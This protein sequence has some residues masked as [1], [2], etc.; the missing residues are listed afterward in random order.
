MW[1][2]CIK[3]RHFETT[4]SI[5]PTFPFKRTTWWKQRLPKNT[6]WI[7]TS[8]LGIYKCIYFNP[9]IIVE[10]INNLGFSYRLCWKKSPRII[11]RLI[12]GGATCVYRRTLVCVHSSHRKNFTF[13]I[14]P[15]KKW[16]SPDGVY[17]VTHLAE[18]VIFLKKEPNS[19]SETSCL[20]SWHGTPVILNVTYHESLSTSWSDSV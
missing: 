10:I 13:T 11:P 20:Y 16:A 17:S 1:E 8:D 18:L 5:Y 6:P 19:V 9:T 12:T 4:F 15:R 3:R 14:H 7:T 2:M